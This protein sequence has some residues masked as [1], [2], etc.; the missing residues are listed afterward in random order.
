MK[1]LEVLEDG[2]DVI[3]F[4]FWKDDFGG[5]LNNESGIRARSWG[6]ISEITQVR[7]IVSLNWNRLGNKGLGTDLK[8]FRETEE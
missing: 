2:W 4:V 8:D 5:G 1:S 3:R 6:S 7:G